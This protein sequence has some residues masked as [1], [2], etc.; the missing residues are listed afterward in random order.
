VQGTVDRPSA[1]VC[2][3]SGPAA[4]LLVLLGFVVISGF[5]P[6]ESP[7]ASAQSI[8]S[9]YANDATQI[10]IGM[11]VTMAG[12]T[13]LLPFG[14]AVATATREIEGQK[15]LSNLQIACV[16]VGALEGVMATF[17]WAAAAFRPGEI[18]PEITRTLNDLGWFAFLF[19]VPPFMVWLGAIGVAILRDPRDQP[20]LPRWAG[21]LNVWIALL[22]FPAALMAFFKHGPFGFNGLLA[23][24]EP[25]F[26]FFTWVVVMTTV[27][28]R[29]TT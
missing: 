9:Y 7:S 22:I 20:L 24:Y 6:P 15:L 21:W 12:F 2:I 13:L 5:V 28:L 25:V 17:I 4:T 10:R 11:L 14:I 18:D 1:Q 26:L 3:W 27:L 8:A 16:A 29:R 23:L 19:D